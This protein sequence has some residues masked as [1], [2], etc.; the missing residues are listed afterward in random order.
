MDHFLLTGATGLL[1]S[2]LLRDL[3]LRGH[4]VTVL[5]RPS[6]QR[7]AQDRVFRLLRYWEQEWK[8]PLPRPTVLSGDLTSDDLGL[9]SQ[10]QRFVQENCTA[11]LHCA[12]SLSFRE[13]NGEPWR[14]NVEGTRRVLQL[15]RRLGIRRLVYV[16]TA[17]VAGLR[18]GTV[19]ENEL[20]VGQTFGNVYEES[21]AAA[22]ELVASEPSLESCVVFRPSIIVGD[23][24]TGHTLTYHGFYTPLRLMDLLLTYLSVEE[25]FSLNYLQALGLEGHEKK[26]LV[27]VDWVSDAILSILQRPH[28][29]RCCY[30]LVSSTPVSAS[31]LL[32]VFREAVW[33]WRLEHDSPPPEPRYKVSLHEAAEIV[34]KLGDLAPI[35]WDQFAVY[36]SYW[37]DD[38]AFDDANTRWVIPDRPAPQMD[39][40]TL[41]RLCRFAL[42]NRFAPP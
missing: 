20:H 26:N 10:A 4:S 24:R 32:Q 18:S 33:R 9:S 6:R 13:K 11:V 38:P 3:L 29:D 22:E 27:P 5:A 19:Y 39:R 16:S 23:S 40:A 21:K 1:G 42:E 7:S 14:T 31:E 37:R 8:R 28:R 17:Y 25:V 41:L 36:Q 30:A 15:C 35:L 12:A 2:Y 34:H